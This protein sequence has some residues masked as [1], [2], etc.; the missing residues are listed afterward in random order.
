MARYEEAIERAKL[1]PENANLSE[2]EVF[3]VQAALL[4]DSICRL[5]EA[6][7]GARFEGA[8]VGADGLVKQG[9]FLL[10][11][12]AALFRSAD[13]QSVGIAEQ[14]LGSLEPTQLDFAN[15]DDAARR[16]GARRQARGPLPAR[17]DAGQRLQ[18]RRD[19][20]DVSSST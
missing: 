9:A 20:G 17:S 2:Q 11:G 6:F 19:R 1:A 3:Q 16:R 18:D 12:P 7:G 8:A 5:E 4:G 15:P 10:L 13:G 14:R